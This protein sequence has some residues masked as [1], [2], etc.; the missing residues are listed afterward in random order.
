MDF[1]PENSLPEMFFPHPSCGWL[2]SN[3]RFF[4][5]SDPLLVFLVTLSQIY[6]SLSH[7]AL[8]LNQFPL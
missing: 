5:L 2:V 6:V 1:G 3:L 4:I 7:Y 8:E